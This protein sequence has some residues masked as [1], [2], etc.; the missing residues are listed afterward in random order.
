MPGLGHL[1][2]PQLLRL[3]RV[4]DV[5]LTSGGQFCILCRWLN[6]SSHLCTARKS[7]T[8][9]VTEGR[10]DILVKSGLDYLPFPSVMISLLGSRENIP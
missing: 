3:D 7:P 8:R 6:S 4:E 9:M 1:H 10:Q 2:T 5:K